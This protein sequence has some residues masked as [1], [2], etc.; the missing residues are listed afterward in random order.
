MSYPRRAERLSLT[1]AQRH[2]ID[3][4]EVEWH[5]WDATHLPVVAGPEWADVVAIGRN[6]VPV[7]V[8]HPIEGRD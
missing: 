7:A 5:G 3:S 1:V 6:G 4:D 8:T 2:A